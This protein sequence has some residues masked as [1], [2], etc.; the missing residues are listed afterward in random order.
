MVELTNFDDLINPRNHGKFQPQPVF[1]IEP[2]SRSANTS[3]KLDETRTPV[4]IVDNLHVKY[5]VYSSGKSVGA[6]GAKRLLQTSTRGI[7]EVHAVKGVSFV[8]YENESIG[9]IGSNGSGKSTLMRTITGLT[10]P[11]AGSV[12]ASSRPNMLGVGAALIPDLSGE[13]NIM[14]GGLALGY[15]R[16]EINA[17]RE[18][19]TKFAELEEFIDLPMRTYSSGM[20]ARL[21]FAIAASKQHDILIV[22]E[23]LAVGDAR[24]RKRSEAKIR[25][26]RENAGTIFHVSHS[27]GSILETCNRVIWIEKGVLMMDGDAKT[28][29]DA[30]KAKKK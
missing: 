2:D 13:K 20:A 27:M 4:V 6:A 21:K 14:L 11:A 9:V 10:S 19:I 5:Q 23:A 28:V 26:I 29:V 17:M 16:Q 25:E 18:D 22:D 1:E 24:F 15:N 12:F 8:A 30:Y 3:V 7:R